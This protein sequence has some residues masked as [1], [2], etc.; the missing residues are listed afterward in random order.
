MGA[1]GQNLLTNTNS[2]ALPQTN[3]SGLPMQGVVAGQSMESI[4]K[5][6]A[7]PVVQEQF[8]KAVMGEEFPY[9]ISV[10]SAQ[11]VTISEN[12]TLEK[13]RPSLEQG[14]KPIGEYFLPNSPELIRQ[15]ETADLFASRGYKVEMLKEM[16]G[17]NG[18]GIQLNTNPDFLIEDR[19]VFDCYTPNK[20]TAIKGIVKEVYDKSKK[21]TP[22]IMINL[23]DY[24]GDMYELETI[25]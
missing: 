8:V 23:N 20:N 9:F 5:S 4:F 17:G 2:P 13:M 1:A 7:L 21:Q 11:Q 24:I 10:S 19:F 15:N 12:I 25:L 18:Y 16:D 22:N 6:T 14:S 3:P